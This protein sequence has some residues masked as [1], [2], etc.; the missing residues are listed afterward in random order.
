MNTIADF[1]RKMQEAKQN[2]EKISS[3]LYMKNLD[4]NLTQIN[5]IDNRTVAVIQ[6][7]SFAL[8]YDYDG[9]TGTSWCDWPKKDEFFPHSPNKV[10]I[11]R[12]SS[13]LIYEFK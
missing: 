5:Q 3:R 6:S 8:S 13:R 12:G 1:K 4:G 10:E 9:K 2:G 7:N 11:I